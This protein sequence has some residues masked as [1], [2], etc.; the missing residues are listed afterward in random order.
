MLKNSH[1]I[2]KN[3]KNTLIVFLYI[4]IR[5]CNNKMTFLRCQCQRQWYRRHSYPPASLTPVP[6]VSFIPVEKFTAIVATV[7]IKIDLEKAGRAN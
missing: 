6:L 7:T 3:G 4:L 2:D 1:P 5:N